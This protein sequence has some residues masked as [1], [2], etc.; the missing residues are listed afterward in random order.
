[1][2]AALLAELG[3]FDEAQSLLADTIAQI[4]ERGL[5]MLAGYAMQMA[6][7]I[8]MLAGDDAAAERAARR[9]CE[10]LHRLGEQGYLS[11]QACQLA[12]ALYALGRYEESGQ[13]AG[14]ADCA[15]AEQTLL[16]RQPGSQHYARRP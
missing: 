15:T 9:G 11:T 14:G 1:M 8:E 5:A 4:N 13:W 6:W 12:D 2:K 7:R 3:S 10:Q 16:L